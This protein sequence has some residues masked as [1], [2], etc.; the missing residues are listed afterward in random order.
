MVLHDWV[1]NFEAVCVTPQARGS[2]Y[3]S[4]PILKAV[5]I[6]EVLMSISTIGDAVQPGM[7]DFK[8]RPA[9]ENERPRTL[10][11]EAMGK[12]ETAV[13]LSQRAVS[14][15]GGSAASEATYDPSVVLHETLSMMN[16][17][18]G[19]AVKAGGGFGH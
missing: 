17:Y 18:G 7:M 3:A 1:G 4:D 16:G 10:S 13:S 8:P 15:V 5:E 19:D 14:N 2:I 9:E 12:A 6:T 11:A